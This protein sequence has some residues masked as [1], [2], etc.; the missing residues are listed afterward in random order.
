MKYF[1]QFGQDHWLMNHMFPDRRA[2]YFVDVGAYHMTNGYMS[3]TLALELH[4]DWTGL[5]IEANPALCGPLKSRKARL[6]NAV[7]SSRNG[8]LG[9]QFGDRGYNSKIV[10]SGGVSVATETLT[11]ILDREKAPSRIE[12]LSIDVEGHELEVL[13]GIDFQRYQFGCLIIEAN[14]NKN[15]IL[16]LLNDEPYQFIGQHEVDLF[17]TSSETCPVSPSEVLLDWELHPERA[18]PI[19][20]PVPVP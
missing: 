6:V 19:H 11:Q 18:R 7:V 14:A 9:F 20:P 16:T 5:L 15:E 10:A 1:S 8:M 17:F 13:K 12:L 2:G 3:N 4:R